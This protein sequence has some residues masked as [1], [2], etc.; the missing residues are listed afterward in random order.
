MF[1]IEEKVAIE[2]IKK[3]FSEADAGLS[4]LNAKELSNVSIEILDGLTNLV[5]KSG[6]AFIDSAIVLMDDPRFEEIALKIVQVKH[7][8]ERK[9][10][11][12]DLDNRAICSKI[13][14]ANASNELSLLDDDDLVVEMIKCKAEVREDGGRM[15]NLIQDN[16]K[17][18][19]KLYGT[20]DL[21]ALVGEER[22][23]M[24]GVYY[25]NKQR[26][27]HFQ[28]YIKQQQ[29][30]LNLALAEISSRNI[31]YF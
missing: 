15:E 22:A 9:A 2:K 10:K 14:R 1:G 29:L 20:A 12:S 23:E 31:K 3:F 8:L 19:K 11:N 5:S 24:I 13:Y 26:I 21:P 27:K 25:L 4:L 30:R 6:D 18:E 16:V 7:N 17:I 28:L